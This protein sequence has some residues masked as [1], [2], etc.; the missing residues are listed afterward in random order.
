MKKRITLILLTLVMI[1][2]CFTT[3]SFG[4]GGTKKMRAYDIIKSKNIVYCAGYDSIYRVNLKNGAVR[5]LYFD[6]A[7]VMDG[8]PYALKLYKGYLYFLDPF[9]TGNSLCRVKAGGG[10]VKNMLNVFDYAIVKGKLFA[11]GYNYINYNKNVNIV[12]KLNGKKVRKCKCRVKMLTD[13]KSNAQGYRINTVSNG[14]GMSS[15]G[16]E[17]YINTEYL[18]KPDGTMI[19]LG[20]VEDPNIYD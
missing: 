2:G 11:S 18:V 1:V 20:R 10:K 5:K 14:K 15:E 16:Y 13:K 12:S 3:V 4:A 7:G 8:G 17:C 19:E 6:E 9:A